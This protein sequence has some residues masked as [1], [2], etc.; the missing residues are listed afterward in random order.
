M[1]VNRAG[2]A[3][4]LWSPGI[5]R[6]PL[7][8]L[9]QPQLL[10]LVC[11]EVGIAFRMELVRSREWESLGYSCLGILVTKEVVWKQLLS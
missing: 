7:L 1:T 10:E 4:S 2:F 6:W 8:C 9:W 3:S 11:W 5:P